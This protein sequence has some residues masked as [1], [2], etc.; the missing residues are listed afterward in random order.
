M[1]Q[2][3]KAFRATRHGRKK[4]GLHLLKKSSLKR[5]RSE[6]QSEVDYIQSKVCVIFST[7]LLNVL[8]H[9]TKNARLISYE[10]LS[11]TK[12]YCFP[13]IH[14][15]DFVTL[16]N[17]IQSMSYT[18][19]SCTFKFF[20]DQLLNGLLGDDINISRGFV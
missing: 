12:F 11:R 2:L 16:N 5:K 3:I 4:G 9:L 1:L 14:D 19:D 15:Q 20:I 17:C 10:R 6:V 13:T 18:Y 8:K 7:R